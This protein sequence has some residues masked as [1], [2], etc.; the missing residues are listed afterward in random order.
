MPPASR[1]PRKTYHHGSLRETL[2]EK[3]V[4]LLRKEGLEALTLRA[5]ARAAKVSQAAPYRHFADRR[6]LLG[7]VAEDGF[8]RLG[9]GMMAHAQAGQS[10]EGF[11]G[12]AIAY[13]D[14]AMANPAQYRLM[15]GGEIANHADLP[16][17]Q[18]TSRGVLGFVAEGIRRLQAAGLVR[19]G[20]PWSMAVGLWS[21]L[22]GLVMIH[23]DGISEGVA[24][25]LPVL[26]D[27]A[28]RIMMFGMA[29]R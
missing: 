20:D 28:M 26:L 17:L 9:Q 23:L 10:R 2:F 1:S 4:E 3:A 18:E 15:F 5:V 11:K 16:S 14:F 19:E 21:M 29:P 27:D 12:F 24:P 22:H 13:V 7:A 6:A 8:R 25:P